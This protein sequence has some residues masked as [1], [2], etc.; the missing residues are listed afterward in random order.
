MQFGN[1]VHHTSTMAEQEAHY[2]NRGHR[3]AG[4]QHDDASSLFVDKLKSSQQ[5]DSASHLRED[6]L[7]LDGNIRIASRKLFFFFGGRGSFFLDQTLR[8][9]RAAWSSLTFKTP[10]SQTRPFLPIWITI[11]QSDDMVR[12]GLLAR[13]GRRLY[14]CG[15]A[16][17]DLRR[18]VPSHCYYP[19]RPMPPN[20]ILSCTCAN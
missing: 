4:C 13:D 10:G 11:T 6:Y 14:V 9:L 5:N 16:C 3:R 8:R 18:C 1:A 19:H 2:Q 20:F 7:S 15:L 12:V 17:R